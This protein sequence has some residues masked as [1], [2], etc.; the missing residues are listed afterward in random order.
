MKLLILAVVSAAIGFCQGTDCDSLEKCQEVLKINPKSSLA[1]YRIGEI[2]FR[3]GDL[4]KAAL[5]GFMEA[6]R[7]DHDPKWTEVWS[8]INLGR[9][10][11]LTDQRH[12]AIVEYRLVLKINDNS[13]G[14]VD[15]AAEY[16]KVP[17]KRS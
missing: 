4:Q 6:A 10:Y 5:D 11:D 12:R 8:H 13:G 7:G 2:Y 1:R 15:E 9:I 14:A 16:I 17:Y 3:Q